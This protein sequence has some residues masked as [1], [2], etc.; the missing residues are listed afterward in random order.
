MLAKVIGQCGEIYRN[1]PMVDIGI[2]VNC[3]IWDY[4]YEMGIL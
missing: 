4:N 3:E 1:V 2:S